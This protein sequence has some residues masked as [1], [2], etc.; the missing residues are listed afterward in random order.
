MARI[1]TVLP[2]QKFVVNVTFS[3]A[4]ENA[5]VVS[6]HSTGGQVFNANNM[7]GQS[8]SWSSPVNN[9]ASAKLYVIRGLHKNGYNDG[10]LPWLDSDERV[11]FANQ[12]SVILGYEDAN[13]GDYNDACATVVFTP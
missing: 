8:Q 2:N 10:S 3:A 6:E 13:D 5:V 9:S 4:H 7:F 1:L 11:L 12:N